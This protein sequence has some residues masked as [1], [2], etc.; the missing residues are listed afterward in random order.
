MRL[1]ALGQQQAGDPEIAALGAMVGLWC[2]SAGAGTLDAALGIP[3]TVRIE[4]RLARRDRLLRE[5]ATRF[6]ADAPS[7]ADALHEALVRHQACRRPPSR[8][9]ADA[10]FAEVLALRPHVPTA[11]HL[12][13]LGIAR[14]VDK[15]S[16]RDVHEA[17]Q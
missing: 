8:S 5:A 10:L 17:V 13:R 16:R 9:P 14:D 2:E 1:A 12:R 7:P 11:R 4:A 15:G 3:A 6:F